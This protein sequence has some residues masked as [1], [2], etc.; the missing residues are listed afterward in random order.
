[1]L[2]LS[3]CFIQTNSLKEHLGKCQHW[4]SLLNPSRVIK[5]ISS[6]RDNQWTQCAC[7]YCAWKQWHFQFN[8]QAEKQGKGVW[9]SK[10]GR[11]PQTLWW[12]FR[13]QRWKRKEREE[14]MWLL[15]PWLSSQISMHEETDWSDGIN[16]LEEQP[17]GSHSQS[18]QEEFKRSSTNKMR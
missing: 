18:F 8:V 15:Q 17:W 13:L 2:F 16:S 6:K 4:I 5:I 14:Q 9:I 7:T 1:M 3:H 11:V 10:E 12:F